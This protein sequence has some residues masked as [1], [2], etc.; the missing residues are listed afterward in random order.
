MLQELKDYNPAMA[1]TILSTA[2]SLV[3]PF[4]YLK[5]KHTPE[6]INQK[7]RNV[8]HEIR[9]K[10]RLHE[11]DNT[12]KAIAKIQQVLINEL[13]D[14]VL[15]GVD[16]KEIKARLGH[17]GNLPPQEYEIKYGESFPILEKFGV[18]KSGILDAIKHPDSFQHL[19]RDKIVGAENSVSLFAKSKKSST[20]LVI[21]DRQGFTLT[22]SENWKIYHDEINSEG[23]KTPLDLLR[24]FVEVFGEEFVIEQ[25]K[26]K[27]FFN[28]K[29]PVIKS[30][31]KN[32]SITVT[33]LE[34]GNSRP[35]IHFQ[36]KVSY[37]NVL[38]G[39]SINFD[40]Y[41]ESLKKHGALLGSK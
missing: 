18:R 16:R 37:I 38:L 11:N 33:K 3:L 40:K 2:S 1:Q 31:P 13:T 26:G 22:V 34:K 25:T 4:E 20:D 27:L 39:Y 8:L 12:P 32:N 6:E 28:E 30:D 36:H 21:A 5:E 29:I 41:A 9:R 10:L 14:S 23:L 24:A 7:A 17:R 35:V 15:S 19:F